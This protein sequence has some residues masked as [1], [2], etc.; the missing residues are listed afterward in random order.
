MVS[1]LCGECGVFAQSG[2]LSIDGLYYKF[3]NG[4]CVLLESNLS[5]ED[6]DV[7]TL[8]NSRMG[9]NL[10][11]IM[12]IVKVNY[13]EYPSMCIGNDQS[14]YPPSTSEWLEDTL[15]D[16]YLSGYSD[17]STHA[18]AFDMAMSVETNDTLQPNLPT[19]GDE[20][21]QELEEGELIPDEPNC[22]I[23]FSSNIGISLEEEN[24]RAQYGQVTQPNEEWISDL[25]MVD[26]WD[27]TLVKGIEKVEKV[28][29]LGWLAN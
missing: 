4:N 10:N 16:M 9:I 2:D 14:E 21:I 19:D 12:L 5:C 7:I 23:D 6:N 28:R 1:T 24:W 13:Y 18:V 29:W 11:Y 15:I 22:L 8:F 20:E 3:E 26:L 27:W 25:H 17:Q